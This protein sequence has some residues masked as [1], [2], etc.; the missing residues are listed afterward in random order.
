MDDNEVVWMHSIDPTEN[1]YTSAEM[2]TLTF[3]EQQWLQAAGTTND[4]NIRNLGIHPMARPSSSNPQIEVSIPYKVVGKHVVI[5]PRHQVDIADQRGDS[6]TATFNHKMEENQAGFVVFSAGAALSANDLVV[7]QQNAIDVS[8]AGKIDINYATT[9][10]KMCSS[11][12]CSHKRYCS[13]SCF[14]CGYCS[15]SSISHIY[16]KGK[17]SSCNGL[18]S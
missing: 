17:H 4:G 8:T 2:K 14:W 12:S 15:L 11:S 10:E 3:L 9:R 7:V 5:S 13:Q 1:Y 18:Q 16:S 6:T